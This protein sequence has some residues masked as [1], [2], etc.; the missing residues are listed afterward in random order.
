MNSQIFVVD[1]EHFLMYTAIVQILLRGKG[2]SMKTTK[3]YE[4]ITSLVNER[5]FVP[6]SEL[7]RLCGVAEM[8]I[9]RDLKMLDSQRRLRRTYGGAVSVHPA[10]TPSENAEIAPLVRETE[11][12]FIDQVD[13]LIATSVNPYYDGLLIDRASKKN[14]PIIAESIELPDQSTVVAVDN[15]QAG[16]D[17]G[18]STG[19]F[20][21]GQGIA[22]ACLL[23]LTF[24]KPNTQMRS[25]AFIDGLAATCP[26]E[27]VLSINAQS[28]YTTA[29]QL[30]YDALTVYPQINVIF[31]INDT[32]ARGAIDACRNLNIDPSHM[33]VITFGLEGDTLKNEL[34]AKSYCKVALAMFPEIVSF[35]CVEAV[36]AAFNHKALPENFIT[37]HVVLTAQTLKDYYN[38][39]P[40]G[41]ELNWE[42]ARAHLAFPIEPERDA[43]QPAANLPRQIGFLVPFTEHEWYKNLT[44]QIISYAGQY[45][46][47]IQVIDAEQNVRDE[48]EIRRRQIAKKAAGLVETGESVL[49]DSGP[50]AGYLAEEL[51]QKKDIT[52]ITNSVIVFDTLKHTPSLTLIS[53]GGTLRFSSQ[54]LVGPT[55]EGALKELR[56]DK[57]FLMV[58]GISL[59]FGL[60]HK[61]ISEITIKQAMIHSTHEVILLAD[62]TAFGAETGIQVAPLS[63]VQRLITDDALP[64]S[65]RLN[66]SKLGIQLMIV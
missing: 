45:G 32:T 54:V 65:I 44:A 6:V 13:G 41:W 42:Y 4:M 52:V 30:A 46:I 57:L 64:P 21:T 16:Y 63:V 39:T 62:H 58:S 47:G 19:Q 35:V 7:S 26:S 48:V 27:V 40:A 22:K 10:A 28:R 53:T 14:I 12:L 66:M 11:V 31:A 56:A 34:M 17:L 38:L 18:V 55:A 20:L 15:Y 23:D 43:A 5:G 29:Y 1:F 33:H 25:R 37:P 49:I 2:K 9:R 8:T 59:D 36:I 51:K 50:I 3:R 24:Q 60:S 61:P